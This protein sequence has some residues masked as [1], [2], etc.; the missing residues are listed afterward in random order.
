MNDNKLTNEEKKQLEDYIM[1]S[2]A[3][4]KSNP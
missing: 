1:D 2:L 3:I 4:L